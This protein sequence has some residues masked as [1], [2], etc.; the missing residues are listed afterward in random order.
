MVELDTASG[1]RSPPLTSGT[2][3]GF[4]RGLRHPE[5]LL[6]RM[7]NKIDDLCAERARL[8]KELKKEQPRRKL[9]RKW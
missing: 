9:G 1:A 6:D 8:M 7:L 5:A 2:A 4:A 3:C